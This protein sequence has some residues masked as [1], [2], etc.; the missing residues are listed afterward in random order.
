MQENPGARVVG[1]ESPAMGD[2]VSL[3]ERFPN[4]ASSEWKGVASGVRNA[5]AAGV[6]VQF[7]DFGKGLSFK[8]DKIISIAPNPSS[9][10]DVVRAIESS[11]V[12]GSRV[13]V[14]GV[15]GE[16][17]ARMIAQGLSE[18]YGIEVRPVAGMCLYPSSSL[19][20]GSAEIVQFVVP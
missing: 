16:P 7:S 1:I 9:A 5:Q 8:A 19:P 2:E 20:G 15:P 3:A 12:S 13:Y 14:A 17:T 10:P 18:V 6:E 11:A 4:I